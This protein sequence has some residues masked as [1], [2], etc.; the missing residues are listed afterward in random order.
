[1]ATLEIGMSLLFT[2]NGYEDFLALA[3]AEGSPYLVQYC[4]GF[5][6]DPLKVKSAVAVYPND[7]VVRVNLNSAVTEVDFLLDFSS[8]VKTANT[9]IV[10]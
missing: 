10:A 5:G 2:M 6:G 3:T 1:M 7:H 9:V 4:C 8:A